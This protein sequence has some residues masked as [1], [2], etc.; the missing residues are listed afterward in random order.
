MSN[1]TPHT[2]KFCFFIIPIGSNK[3][4]S[5]CKPEQCKFQCNCMAQ[6]MLFGPINADTEF[7]V[8]QLQEWKSSI[9]T[10]RSVMEWDPI[11]SCN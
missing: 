6:V 5:L 7:G 8:E 3:Q 4:A 11:T 1:P 9:D 2:L 10:L